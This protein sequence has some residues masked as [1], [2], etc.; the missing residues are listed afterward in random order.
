MYGA[1]VHDLPQNENHKLAHLSF[2]WINGGRGLTEV[3]MWIKDQE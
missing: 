2:L 3:Q 1:D